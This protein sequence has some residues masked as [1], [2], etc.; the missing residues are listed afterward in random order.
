MVRSQVYGKGDRSGTI[1]AILM[2]DTNNPYWSLRVF[3][4]CYQHCTN[5]DSVITWNFDFKNIDRVA[6]TVK[7]EQI[8][9]YLVAQTQLI[10]NL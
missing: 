9:E 1:R 5:K 8:N 10:N 2:Y 6:N 4:G 7:V 3:I